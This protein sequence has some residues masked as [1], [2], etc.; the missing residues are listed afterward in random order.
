MIVYR[1]E[2]IITTY[3]SKAAQQHSV[4]SS[5]QCAGF[6][7]LVTILHLVPTHLV[8][9]RHKVVRTHSTTLTYNARGVYTRTNSATTTQR[10]KPT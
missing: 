3:R 8:I 7:K 4:L 5:I 6:N 9:Q 1:D 10:A 2:A